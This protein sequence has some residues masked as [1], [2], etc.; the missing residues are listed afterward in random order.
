MSGRIGGIMELLQTLFTP[1]RESVIP[2]SDGIV[3]DEGGREWL[4]VVF[5]A[6][7]CG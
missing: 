4:N 3:R 2:G 7:Q 5:A 6:T 1:F